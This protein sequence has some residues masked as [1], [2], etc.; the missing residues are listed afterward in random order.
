M[1]FTDPDLWEISSMRGMGVRGK[2]AT[3]KGGGSRGGW[4]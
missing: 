2:G 1:T 3:R 4:D